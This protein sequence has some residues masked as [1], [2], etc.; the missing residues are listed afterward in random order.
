MH[1]HIP[2][3]FRQDIT[4]I[5]PELVHLP[6]ARTPEPYPSA[7][8]PPTAE[9]VRFAR[10]R[11]AHSP[12]QRMR[13]AEGALGRKMLDSRFDSMPSTV[14]ARPAAGHRNRAL[15]ARAMTVGPGSACPDVHARP[16]E[17]GAQPQC[18]FARIP[19][20][21]RDYG[22]AQCARPDVH[23][24][25]ETRGRTH[26]LD[27]PAATPATLIATVAMPASHAASPHP[28]I[29]TFTPFACL[30]PWFA[31]PRAA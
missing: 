11:R 3:F 9:R 20:R 27:L 6:C 31:S 17:A 18:S 19:G 26:R 14:S 21:K 12:W 4:L 29:F 25:T 8:N 5:R 1:V 28:R 30:P 16:R 7:A 23:P 15:P 10:A 13:R 2:I 24:R 22:A